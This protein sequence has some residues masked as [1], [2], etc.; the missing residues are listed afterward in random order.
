MRS[1]QVPGSVSRAWIALGLIAAGAA[2][3]GTGAGLPHW[4]GGP[5]RARNVILFIGDGM[6]IATL[7]AARIFEGQQRGES[8]EENQL[9]FE[10]FPY[11]ALVKTY[12]SD[13]Q[14]PDSAGT[15]TAIVTGV[16]TRAGLISIGP[17]V[18]RGDATAARA[19]FLP[20]LFERAEQRGLATGFVTTT[21]LT[22]ATPAA[23]Y[24][25]APDRDWEHD[26][27]L[28]EAA[29]REG[30][31]DIA[32][33][34]IEFR[35]GDGPDLALGGGRERFWPKGEADP[36]QPGSRGERDDGRNLAQ[37]WVASRPGGVFVWNRE[38]LLAL[39]PAQKPRVL[40]L[41]ERSHMHYEHDRAGDAGGEPSLAEMTGFA[42][43][44]LAAR[45]QGY[46]L[47][48]EGGRI[49]HAHHDA[50]AF[51]ALSETVALSD[52]VRVAAERTDPEQTL[53]VVTAD[54]SHTLTLGGHPARGNPILGWVA[55]LDERGER[56]AQPERDRSGQ[57]YTALAYA[58]GPK[59]VGAGRRTRDGVD[60]A[61]PDYHQEFLVPLLQESHG[62]EDVAVFARGPGAEAFHGLHEQNWI[63]DAI[64]AALGWP[65]PGSD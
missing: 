7:T 10:R 57:T 9:S 35:G 55:T 46:L 58:N 26:G 36:E 50:N 5:P 65:V 59:H 32:R 51:R 3:A 47:M 37:E 63:H 39:D 29:R 41:F 49:D 60:P 31:P 14:V 17:E 33:Q 20:T 43:E 38:Q 15:M 48:I 34:L 19:H 56:A 64:T 1:K 22:H 6:G 23:C 53:I 40:G 52:A 42:I 30:F 62:G 11:T 28:P 54:H 21:R 25:H 16:K 45:D 27:T 24:A 61:Q 12:N 44:L 4:L 18:L 2:C 8:G 13:A